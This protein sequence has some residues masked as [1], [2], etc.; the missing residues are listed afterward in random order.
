MIFSFI[1][2][3]KSFAITR[4]PLVIFTL[5]LASFAIAT[6]ALSI[7]LKNG[8]I[9]N[10]DV[11]DWNS[12]MEQ[13]SEWNLCIESAFSSHR[14]PGTVARDTLP[15]GKTYM[16]IASKLIGASSTIKP[17]IESVS[18]F[19]KVQFSYDVQQISSKIEF[20]HS[21]FSLKDLG[22]KEINPDEKITYTI[23]LGHGNNFKN[24]TSDGYCDAVDVCVTFSGMTQVLPKPKQSRTCHSREP[25]D[26]YASFILFDMAKSGSDESSQ[27]SGLLVQQQ[28]V[29]DPFL[30]EILSL[31]EQDLINIHLTYTSYFLFVMVITILCFA[32]L[33]NH[34]PPKSQMFEKVA[35]V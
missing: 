28:F 17:P 21:Y 34:K 2:N 11:K 19:L 25:S 24:C 18:V 22:F 12:V 13:M 8:P 27:C 30:D 14:K 6:L 16:N 26:N 4:P 3:L 35:S 33:R 23:D 7:Y 9:R 20:L 1:H 5:C 10:P 29:H 15:I 32:M 31:N